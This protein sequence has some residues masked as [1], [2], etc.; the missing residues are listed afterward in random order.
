MD[1]DT[2]KALNK[3]EI[4]ENPITIAKVKKNGRSW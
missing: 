2:R 4:S 1:S 3:S